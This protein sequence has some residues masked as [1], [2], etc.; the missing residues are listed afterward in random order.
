MAPHRRRARPGRP[1]V[2]AAVVVVLATLAVGPGSAAGAGTVRT[3]E[4]PAPA[5]APSAAARTVPPFGA[6]L[7]SGRGGSRGWPR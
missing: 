2:I 6:F 1:A 3:P 5:P 7:D 4:P